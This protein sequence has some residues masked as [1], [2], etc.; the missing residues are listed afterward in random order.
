MIDNK[1]PEKVQVKIDARL[2]RH[3]AMFDAFIRRRRWQPPAL[4]AGI[5]LFFALAAYLMRE[6]APQATMLAGVLLGV[7]VVLPLVYLVSY[8][9]S[10][11]A[12]IKKMKLD[13]PRAAYSLTLDERGMDVNAGKTTHTYEWT[14][15][16]AAYRRAD[17]TYLYVSAGQAYLL[18]H[19]QLSG[20]PDA[21][22]E[23]LSSQMQS[24]KLHAGKRKPLKIP[25]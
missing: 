22:W 24:S 7:G 3:F 12:Q 9:L 15:L 17:C 14:S 2:F 1:S 4:F 21:L 6:R 10:I 8:L 11:R 16:Y 19:A 20:G 18:P 5:F 13:K 25:V 23:L